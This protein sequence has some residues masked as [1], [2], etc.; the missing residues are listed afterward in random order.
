MIDT[1]DMRSTFLIEER[2]PSP[3]A[4]RGLRLRLLGGFAAWVDGVPLDD[5]AWSRRKVSR[6]VKL[7]A[8]APEQR[9]HREQVE[10]LLWPSLGPRAAS[11]NLHH[12]LYRARHTLE[13]GLQRRAEP[14]FLRLH[15][16][17]LE[18]APCDRFESDLDTFEHA[19]ATAL[20]S[21]DPGLHADAVALFGGELLPEERFEDW[22]IDRR[23][24]VKAT[25]VE[26]LLELAE[27]ERSRTRLDPAIEA[28]KRIVAVEPLHEDA[29]ARLIFLDGLAGRRHLAVAHYQRFRDVLRNELDADP[30][31]TTVEIYESVISGRICPG[32]DRSPSLPRR[33]VANG[34]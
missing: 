8:L 33:E 16:D 1:L 5:G 3:T 10:W 12:T 26:L 25:Y 20:A 29:Q 19:A 11:Q 30:L 2:R 22:A 6:L 18:L 34:R 21:G 27:L 32:F 4:G 15:N 7:L 31:P 28:L 24:T 14:R 17:L 9:L 23:D 13:P